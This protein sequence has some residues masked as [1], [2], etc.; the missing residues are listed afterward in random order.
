MAG[1]NIEPFYSVYRDVTIVGEADY[2]G[3]N[4]STMARPDSAGRKVTHWRLDH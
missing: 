1:K 2:N 4:G 3:I